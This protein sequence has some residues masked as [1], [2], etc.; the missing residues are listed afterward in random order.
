MVGNLNITTESTTHVQHNLNFKKPS[1][2]HCGNNWIIITANSTFRVSP[3]L[4]Y[5]TAIPKTK[6]ILVLVSVFMAG[7]PCSCAMLVARRS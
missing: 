6:P 7:S 1:G 4:L 2:T 3:A 5:C